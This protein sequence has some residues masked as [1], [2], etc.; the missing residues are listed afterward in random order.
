MKQLII[1]ADDFGLT[2]SVNDGIAM[3]CAEGIVTHVNLI[4]TG[5]AFT[6]A[7]ER[8]DSIKGVSVGAHLALTETAPLLRAE[9][10]HSIVGKDRR[11]YRHSGGFFLR[12]F[13]G[14]IDMA[15]AYLELKAQLEAIMKAG[16]KPVNLSSHEHIHM[17]P[18]MLEVFVRLA[19]EYGIPSIR[20]FY[21]KRMARPVTAGK[22]FKALAIA[23]LGRRAREF[24]SSSGLSSTDDFFGFY[25]S[26]HIDEKRLSALIGFIGEG[27]CELVT[28]PGFLGPEVIDRYTFHRNCEA[29]LS[30]LTSPRVRR[31]IHEKG[32]ELTGF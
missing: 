23:G 13:F 17:M 2:K 18:S 27:V 22:I 5:E 6:D 7:A 9:K 26:G 11:F 10:V 24:I 29:E 30:A 3:A 31:L 15:E 28:H 14:K 20:C 12:L 19:K 25:D 1:S 8:I 4:P 21:E 16:V 32:I